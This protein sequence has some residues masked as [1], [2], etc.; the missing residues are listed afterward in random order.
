[1]P[2][3]IHSAPA[4]RQTRATARTPALTRSTLGRV[5]SAL[6][7]RLCSLRST[8]CLPTPCPNRENTEMADA[9]TGDLQA[10]VEKLPGA[11]EI[12]GRAPGENFSVASSVLGPDNR[13]HLTAIYGYARLVDQIGDAVDG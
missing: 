5:G 2:S 10:A 9:A 7:N 1:M 12:Y 3:P 6:V 13:R 4:A 8:V 11:A